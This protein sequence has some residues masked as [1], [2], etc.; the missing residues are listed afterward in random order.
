MAFCHKC[1]YKLDPGD[2]FCFECGAKVRE[3]G[4]EKVN[5]SRDADEDKSKEIETKE[6]QNKE[7]VPSTERAKF[8]RLPLII[9]IVVVSIVLSL[10]LILAIIKGAGKDSS[11]REDVN[12]SSTTIK[13]GIVSKVE[14][15]TSTTTEQPALS[16]WD[17]ITMGKYP[18]DADGTVRDIEWIVIDIQDGKAMVISKY[19]LDSRQFDYEKISYG[20]IIWPGCSLRKW[21]NS[22]FYTTA[23]SAE[24]QKI[25]CSTEVFT[26]S[27]DSTNYFKKSSTDKVFL[28]SLDEVKDKLK[29]F[30]SASPTAYCLKKGVNC[31]SKDSSR[32]YEKAKVSYTCY[33]WLR[34]PGTSYGPL[35]CYPNGTLN[36][37]LGHEPTDNTWGV[38]PA[39][40]IEI[41]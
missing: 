20:Q 38:R 14:T 12:T 13:N 23:F 15:T 41:E 29:S 32:D 2:K 11:S 37:R 19:V 30:R 22:E 40:W 33:W 8:N 16:K 7:A 10:S 1:G 36:E 21:L 17:T 28:L 25:I 31:A 4:P 6:I 24:E 18:Q 26:T 3:K 34:T 5:V 9:S 35:Y 27:V 39:M